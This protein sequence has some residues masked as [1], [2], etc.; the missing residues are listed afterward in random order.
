[1]VNFSLKININLQDR[2]SPITEQLIYLH[3]LKQNFHKTLACA[4]IWTYFL[5]ERVCMLITV[6]SFPKPWLKIIAIFVTV[7]EGVII[8]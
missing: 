6:T 3:D 2:A 7:I 5:G 1:M 4:E 8:Y